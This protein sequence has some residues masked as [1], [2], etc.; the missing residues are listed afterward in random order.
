MKK[1]SFVTAVAIFFSLSLVFTG[2]LPTTGWAQSDKQK[3]ILDTLNRM[4]S[5]IRQ[6][7]QEI[8]R[9]KQELSTIKQGQEQLGK[10]QQETIQKSVKQ[11]V[12]QQFKPLAWAK[13]IKISGD[14]R[15]RYE[16]MYNRERNGQDIQDRDRFRVRLR[17][18]GDAQVTDE[19]GAH[20]MLTTS[21]NQFGQTSNNS[22]KEEFDNKAI[23]IGRA[24]ADYKPKWMPGLEVGMGK[25][26]NPFVHSDISWDPDINPEGFYELYTYKGWKT[27][28]PFVKFGQLIISENNLTKD[29]SLF[30][31]QGGVDFTISPVKF[32]LAGS[33]YDYH[34]LERTRL[35]A[36]NRSLGNSTTAD[37]GTGDP[38]L[39][40]DFK[41]AE[42][43]GFAGFE[44]FKVPVT[45][46]GDYLRNTA[47]GVP[48]DRDTAWLLGLNVG[49][50]REAGDWLV[51]YYYK[52]IESDAVLGL[53]ADGDFFGTNREGH[54]LRLTYQLLK[55]LSLQLAIFDTDSIKGDNHETRLQVSTI[56]KF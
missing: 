42:F 11:E 15:L 41:I 22:L 55:S 23:F 25:F 4:E 46:W 40:Y 27:V 6:Q 26:K 8:E 5:V 45:I 48:N 19:I 7:Q 31:W 21:E 39:A 28:Q 51:E 17:V 56:F 53:F 29:G 12:D 32:T 38:I 54:R 16:G 37:P 1:H 10:E 50:T 3:E 49:K 36:S 30:L 2:I 44:V 47:G 33:Y 13:N 14:L 24:W 34:N 52:R 35:G 9:L 43:I 18:Y 20:F